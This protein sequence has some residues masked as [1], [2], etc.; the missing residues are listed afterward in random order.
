MSPDDCASRLPI[1]ASCCPGGH[2]T[3]V[4]RAGSTRREF[5]AAAGGLGVLGTALTGLSWAGPSRRDKP[6]FTY[7]KPQRSP[8]TSWRNWGGIQ[9]D[10]DIRAEEERIRG[11]L[12]K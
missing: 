8:M 7:P 3:G 11:E 9:T 10:A 4:H 5:L 2:A 1:H 12:G 6:I